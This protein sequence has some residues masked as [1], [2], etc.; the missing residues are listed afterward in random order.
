MRSS[1]FETKSFPGQDAGVIS[2]F[3]TRMTWVRLKTLEAVKRNWKAQEG[4]MH[5]NF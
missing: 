5:R 2:G 4:G 3:M 1:T